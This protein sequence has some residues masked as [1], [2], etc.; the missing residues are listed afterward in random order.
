VKGRAALYADGF[1]FYYGVTNHYRPRREELGYSL[2]GLCWCN[3]R[4][5]VERY[6]AGVELLFVKYFTAPVTEAVARGARPGE[7]ERYALWRKAA[8]SIPGLRV[9][10]GRYQ[11]KGEDRPTPG[12]PA[13]F[14]EE[15]Q[16]DVQIGIEMVLDAL[17]PELQ[18]DTLFLLTG[19]QDL[20][21]AVWACAL[22]TPQPK[23]VRVLL[24]PQ[25]RKADAESQLREC[26]ARLG[27]RQKA[28]ERVFRHGEARVAVHEL[29]EDWL[30][31]SLLSYHPAPGVE[32]PEYWR[33]HHNYLDKH[34]RPK[35]RPDR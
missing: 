9:V 17:D 4:A 32:C 7:A 28:G 35:W 19:D 2:S 31:N 18:L 14:R 21:P 13:H 30:A 15:K 8:E 10:E 33:L 34:C 3:F 1:N 23:E 26:A 11:A 22:R 16:T 6:F 29:D 5:L 20:W 12:A 27:A 25:T 24:P